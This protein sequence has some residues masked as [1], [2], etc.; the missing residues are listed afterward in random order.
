VN[1]HVGL[2]YNGYNVAW[3]RKT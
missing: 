2:E 3:R 1:P